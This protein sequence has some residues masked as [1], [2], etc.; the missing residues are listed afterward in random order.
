MVAGESSSRPPTTL[1][2]MSVALTQ[3]MQGF[4]QSYFETGL[5]LYRGVL[6]TVLWCGVL[7]GIFWGEEG[8]K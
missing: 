4:S 1:T 2:M 8:E 3:S 7:W 6:L 5:E